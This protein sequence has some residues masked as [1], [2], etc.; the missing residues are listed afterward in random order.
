VALAE[1]RLTGALGYTHEDIREVIAA[2]EDGSLVADK[3]VTATL[4]L[5]DAVVKGFEQLIAGKHSHVK[6]LIQPNPAE[7]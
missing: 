5:E 4:P 7:S 1:K 3:M 6:V 2:L